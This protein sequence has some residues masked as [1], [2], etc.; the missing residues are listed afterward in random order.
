MSCCYN[1]PH[2]P[3]HLFLDYEIIYEIIT[4]VQ[5]SYSI[6]AFRFLKHSFSPF[7]QSSLFTLFNPPLHCGEEVMLGKCLADYQSL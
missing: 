1:K 7:P 5:T 3:L 4:I 2:R 6:L